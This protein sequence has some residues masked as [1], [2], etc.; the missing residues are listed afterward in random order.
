ME[1]LVLCVVLGLI[2]AAI[3]TSKNKD[4]SFAA[5]WIY[6]TLLFIIALIHSLLKQSGGAGVCPDCKESIHLSAN[7]CKHCGARFGTQ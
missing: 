6:G 1:F 4:E 5:W 7:V 3:A 2:P